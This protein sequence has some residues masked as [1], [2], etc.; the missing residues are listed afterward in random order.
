MAYYCTDTEFYNSDYSCQER[1]KNYTR[2]VHSYLISRASY[3]PEVW[4]G[5]HIEVGE[6]IVSED[7]IAERCF[8]KRSQVRRAI[9]HL[10]NDGYIATRKVAQK[11]AKRTRVIKVLKYAVFPRLSK[12]SSLTSD[13]EKDGKDTSFQKSKDINKNCYGKRIVI[14]SEEDIS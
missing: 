14:P 2:S 8:L 4:R 3:K 12:K 13:Q 9:E 7:K 11:V 6:C 5:I 1:T 10:E